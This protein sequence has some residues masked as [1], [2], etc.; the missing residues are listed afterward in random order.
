MS[1]SIRRGDRRVTN[2]VGRLASRFGLLALGV[3]LAGVFCL[4][5]PDTFPT[6][7]TA[8]AILDSQAIIA[9]LALAETLVVIVGQ[10]DLS[11][12]YNIGLSHL[13]ALGLIVRSGLPWPMAVVLV[14]L[15][16]ALIG[17]AN[18]L[19]VE[20]FHVDS[21][22]ATLG[23]GTVVYAIANWYSA[24]QQV[25][26]VLPLGFVNI[27]A[28][29]LLGLP[30]VGIYVVLLLAGLWVVLDYTAVGRYL[31]A[32][33]GNRK[34]AELSGIRARPFVIGA[35]VAAGIISAFAGVVLASRLQIGDVGNGPDYLLPTFV[36]AMLGS[37]TI[38]PGRANPLGTVVAVL[39]LGIGIAGFQQLGGSTYFIVPLFNGSTLLLGVGLAVF[40]ARRVRQVKTPVAPPD[41]SMPIEDVPSPPTVTV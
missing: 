15:S 25:T 35:F 28:S 34:A 13:L 11:V 39:V 16:G 20:I 9:M 1:R 3:V 40:A 26:G 4:L 7:T 41:S 31:Y 27:Y 2:T 29:K 30:A 22:I 19:A 38:K 23:V 6:S 5:L 33:G 32:L 21:F 24:Q 17:L 10:F 37:T 8:L 14:L 36:G 12:A 18:G